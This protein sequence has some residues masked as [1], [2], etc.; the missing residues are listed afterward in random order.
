MGEGGKWYLQALSNLALEI[1]GVQ[2]KEHVLHFPKL[3]LEEGTWLM[4][5]KAQTG[6]MNLDPHIKSILQPLCSPLS[7]YWH[8]LPYYV[9]I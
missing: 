6:D 8:M 5:D 1:F 9:S 7:P 2:V 4:I 3:G